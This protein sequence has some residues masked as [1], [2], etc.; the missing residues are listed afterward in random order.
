[1][2]FAL[3]LVI[4]ASGF[5]KVKVS[6][7]SQRLVL[8][9]ASFTGVANVLRDGSWVEIDTKLLVPGDVLE[10]SSKDKVLPVDCI[11]IRGGG[12]YNSALTINSCRG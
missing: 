10:I 3:T 7:K 5:L 11:L 12:I 4:V 9:M 2:G 6:L 1:M 8:E